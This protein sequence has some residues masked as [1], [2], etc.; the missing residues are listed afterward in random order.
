MWDPKGKPSA[1][2]DGAFFAVGAAI[3]DGAAAAGGAVGAVV[4]MVELLLR[5]RLPEGVGEAE[6]NGFALKIHPGLMGH[7]ALEPLAGQAVTPAV[8]DKEGAGLDEAEGDVVAD[9]FLPQPLDPFKMAGPTAAVVFA[10][11]DYLF[12][13]SVAR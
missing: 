7:L 10:A 11:A 4:G 5:H 13:L 3:A 2:G 9:T 6:V 12:N 8:L 1:V